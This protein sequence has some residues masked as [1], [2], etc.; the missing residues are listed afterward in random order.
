MS[1][2]DDIDTVRQAHNFD[3]LDAPYQPEV[4][5]VARAA[6]RLADEVDRLM[7]AQRSI[8]ARIPE[9]GVPNVWD[10]IDACPCGYG[11]SWPCPTTEAHWIARGITDLAAH[12]RRLIGPPPAELSAE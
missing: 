12:Q 3:G 6:E 8:V 1:I 10:G 7:A 4:L 2:Q 5:A 9:C 11:G